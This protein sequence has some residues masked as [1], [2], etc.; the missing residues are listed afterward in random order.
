MTQI[1]F[2]PYVGPQF[3]GNPVRL[4]ILG[5][6][7]HGNDPSLI[8]STQAVVEK[9]QSREWAIRFLTIGARIIS[10]Q[11]AHEIDRQTV[12]AQIA[13][14]NFIQFLMPYHSDRPTVEQARA[15]W[16]AFRE[17]LG[18]LDPTHI[19]VTG[20]V[21]LWSNM[22]PSDGTFDETMYADVFLPRREYLTP[23]GHAVAVTI[24]HLTRASA[25]RWQAP[26]REF[27]ARPPAESLSLPFHSDL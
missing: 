27:L 20:R 6:S 8:H 25:P 15:S 24:P 18:T 3:A 7:H 14:Y 23:S 17:V 16:P 21:F 10:G 5:E 4:L 1:V 12:F 13:F 2:A 22:P 11:Q 19:L 26:V 9:W